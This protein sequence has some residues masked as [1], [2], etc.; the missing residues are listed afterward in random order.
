[1]NR[2]LNAMNNKR[3]KWRFIWV[4]PILILIITAVPK[5]VGMEFMVN[6]MKDAGMA[7]MTFWVGIIELSCVLFFLIPKTRNIGFLLTVAYT[8]GIIC[9]QWVA[10]MSVV[11]GMVIQ[12]VMWVGM[13]FEQ[14]E[15]FKIGK[16][17]KF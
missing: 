11:P 1:M 17:R 4:L 12:I 5:I 3:S 16:Q 15:F 9:A 6:N 7:H 8:G 2:T 14:P 13:R 10:G